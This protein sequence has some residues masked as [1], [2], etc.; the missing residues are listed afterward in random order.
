M[1]T[2]QTNIRIAL[3]LG[4]LLAISSGCSGL[5]QN[6]DPPTVSVTAFRPVTGE[7]G[8]LNFE[9]DLRIVNPNRQDL[10]IEGVAYTIALEG[11]RLI[12]GVGKDL[13]KIPGYG[14]ATVTLTASAS[15]F[16][17]LQ[18]MG[19]LMTRPKETV[20]YDLETKIDVGAFQR[21]IRVEKSG[22]ISLQPAG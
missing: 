13:P 14:E 18:L 2:R 6:L 3:L 20:T 8:G 15:M 22:E 5:Q 21:P 17:A 4:L 9:I 16:E 10:E 1:R 7:S 12:T 11:R 19:E